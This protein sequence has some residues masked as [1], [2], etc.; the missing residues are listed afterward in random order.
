ML[1][2]LWSRSSV[3]LRTFSPTFIRG[4]KFKLT[5]PSY[6]W[7]RVQTS[8]LA[9]DSLFN[10]WGL[11]HQCSTYQRLKLDQCLLPRAKLKSK[12]IKY[13]N[14]KTKTLNL[15]KLRIGR[16]LVDIGVGKDFKT[17]PKLHMKELT[18][19]ILYYWKNFVR[20]KK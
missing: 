13:T 9:K 4:N 14:I 3:L 20:Q 5:Q 6:H 16:T 15:P 17:K 18:T 10:K 12:W 7:Q 19:G 1:L 2:E 11:K 8:P